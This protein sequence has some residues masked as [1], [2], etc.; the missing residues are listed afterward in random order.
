MHLGQAESAEPVADDRLRRLPAQ[1]RPDRAPNTLPALVRRRRLRAL[2]PV[3]ANISW[4]VQDEKVHC[5]A[6][7]QTGQPTTHSRLAALPGRDIAV[8]RTSSARGHGR[9]ESRSIKTCGITDELGGIAFP[10]PTWPSECTADASRPA[11]AGLARASAPSPASMPTRAAR[12]D[13]VAGIRGHSVH[14]GSAPRAMAT[15]RNLGIG[16]LKTLGADNIAKTTR[17]VRDN[18]ERARPLLGI[19]NNRDT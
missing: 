8:Q 5:I 10:T 17:A 4:L 1:T 18:P 16:V 14:A 11:G 13:L 3:K 6:V 15:L 7:I 19:T 2:H 12:P 9:Q